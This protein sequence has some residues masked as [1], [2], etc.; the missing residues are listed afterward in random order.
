M[1]GCVGGIWWLSLPLLHKHL[2]LFLSSPSASGFDPGGLRRWVQRT[3]VDLGPVK[4]TKFVDLSRSTSRQTVRPDEYA[5]RSPRAVRD[6]TLW[7]GW[8]RVAPVPVSTLRRRLASPSPYQGPNTQRSL[9]V[10][11]SSGEVL[12]L[13][14][15]SK[16]KRDTKVIT[17][18]Q[19]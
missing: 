5:S 17:S 2:A 11:R 14:P 3:R 1:C 19:G 18:C 7:P 12:W 10:S 15:R 6:R 8:D 16:T 13:V 4:R 9:V